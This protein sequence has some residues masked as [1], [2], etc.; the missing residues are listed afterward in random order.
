MPFRHIQEFSCADLNCQEWATVE[1]CWGGEKRMDA[2]EEAL[3]H[4][5]PGRCHVFLFGRISLP[6]SVSFTTYAV[7]TLTDMSGILGVPCFRVNLTVIKPELRSFGL[8]REFNLGSL[9]YMHA[10]KPELMLVGLEM[11]INPD[12]TNAKAYREKGWPTI[13]GNVIEPLSRVFPSTW[14]NEVIETI[15]LAAH[16]QDAY[17]SL[18][19]DKCWAA[20]DGYID[21]MKWGGNY[22]QV[23]FIV[24]EQSK[25]R[26]QH[27]A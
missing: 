18:A 1:D 23:L 26:L 14:N 25:H 19:V 27:Q 20:W 7:R 5:T 3:N 11:S 13:T 21:F 24:G 17:P 2:F 15:M 16:D 8:M 6:G 12:D 4:T 9:Q 10:T 22:E